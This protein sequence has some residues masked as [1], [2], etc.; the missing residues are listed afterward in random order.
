MK[1]LAAILVET[2][3]PLVLAELDVPP[4]QAGQ[5][6]VE[7]AFS[8]VC[9][10]QLLEARGRRGPDA[11][12]PHCLGH[13]GTGWV[14]E[15]GPGVQRVKSGDP[16]I[17]SW[18]KGPGLDARG[19]AYG[20]QGR[21][22]NAGGV[23]TFGRHAVVA[24]NRLTVLP[25][26]VSMSEAALLGCAVPTG[27]GSVWNT[28]RP[29]AGQ[30]LAVFGAGGIG[31][32]ALSAAKL[33][34][35]API[36]AVEPR[37]DRREAAGRMGA[38]HAVDPG[39][40]DAMAQIQRLCPGGLDF[41]V[42]AS[43]RPLAM[44]QALESVRRQGGTAVVAGNAHFGERIELD[45][46]QLNLG[47]RLLG[48]WGGDNTPESDFPKYI[49][50]LAERKLDLSPLLSRAYSLADANRAL[51]DLEAGRV[52]RPVIDLSLG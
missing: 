45:P 7:L 51:D 15:A 44:K 9:H 11:F 12:L 22:V 32:C 38:T 5:V 49:R 2:G 29:R 34:G 46:A 52:I 26:R 8:G 23:T 25:P 17:L 20:W 28:A 41:A 35:C 1:T 31:L 40:A 16:V 10:T 19:T 43:G 50:L 6:L 18:I 47:K 30:S 3:R 27:F 48:T 42:E 4:L 39:A 37:P 13:E 36:I 14:R 33:A 24:E 21:K